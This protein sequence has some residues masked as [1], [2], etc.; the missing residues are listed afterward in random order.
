MT[1]KNNKKNIKI[2]ENPYVVSEEEMKKFRKDIKKEYDI[3]TPDELG[4]I[5]EECANKYP[6]IW[7]LNGHIRIPR[8]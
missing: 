7:A 8:R 6:L 2:N 4:Y 5:F 1:R 3:K